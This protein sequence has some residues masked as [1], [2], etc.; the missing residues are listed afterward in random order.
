MVYLTNILS[1]QK[2][3]VGIIGTGNIGSDLLIKVQKSKYLECTIFAGINK[4]S[5]NIIRAKK[6]G[7][8]V[9]ADSIK[10][11]EKNPDLCEIVF[12]ATSA[13][14]HKENAPILK[15]L[16]KFVIDLTPSRVGLMCIPSINL[17]K[18]IVHDNINLISCGAQATAP[19]VKAI[20]KIHPEISYMELVS[21]I[22]SLSAG[23][24]TRDNIDEYTQATSD[25]LQLF[26]NVKKIKTIINLNPSQPPIVMHNTLYVQIEKPKLRF[27]E[28]AIKA[29]E[30]DIQRYVPGYSLAMSPS[31]TNGIY[32]VMTKVTGQGDFLPSYAGNLDIINCAAIE[33][34]EEYAKNRISKSTI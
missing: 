4:N 10:A 25:A 16:G 23:I 29:V 22:S 6:M 19:L 9:S 30:S 12:D 3:K 11:F 7:I 33:V 5:P 8:N 15:K 32:I 34:A 20:A 31:Y 26:G 21:S 28:S 14:V 27:L 24:G 2:V 1:M 13:K 17:E 18:A